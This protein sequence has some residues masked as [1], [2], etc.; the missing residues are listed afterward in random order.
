MSCLTIHKSK[1]FCRDGTLSFI[2]TVVR[3][4]F[5]TSLHHDGVYGNRIMELE[6]NG[7]NWAL[8]D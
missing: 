5:M 6:Q 8:Q 7:G 2:T 4:S 1:Q 3:I